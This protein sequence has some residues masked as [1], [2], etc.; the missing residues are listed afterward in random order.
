MSWMRIAVLAYVV[1]VALLVWHGWSQ[2][3]DLP[4]QVASHFDASGRPDAWSSRDDYARTTWLLNGFLIVLFAG[5][6]AGLNRLPAGLINIPNRSWWLAPQ[7]ADT[8]RAEI[9]A[10]VLGLGAWMFLFLLFL[11][12][13]IVRVNRGEMATTEHLWPGLGVFLAGTAVWTALLL[14]RYLRRPPTPGA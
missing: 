11:E 13:R 1:A 14:R 7:R 3:P 12:D 6:A 4:E 10:W 5:L 9:A 2:L 8:T